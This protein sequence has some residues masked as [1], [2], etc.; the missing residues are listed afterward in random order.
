MTDW[1][2]IDGKIA[3]VTGA[4]GGIGKAIAAAFREAGC[5]VAVLD[6][7]RDAARAVAAELGKDALAI[8]CDVTSADSVSAAAAVVA[9]HIMPR[10]AAPRAGSHGTPTGRKPATQASS[11]TGSARATARVRATL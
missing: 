3:V 4:A 5:K 2:G 9:T 11:S 10:P 6:I 8:G 1:L 7:N